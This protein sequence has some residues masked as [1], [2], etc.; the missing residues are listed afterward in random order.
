MDK[1]EKQECV[2]MATKMYELLE[3]SGKL[4]KLGKEEYSGA[5]DSGKTME[6]AY[7]ALKKTVSGVVGG[8]S[9]SSGGST[10]SNMKFGRT[11]D[12]TATK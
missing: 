8:K 11:K 12:S 5:G 4:K 6:S 3:D 9:D 1:T 7:G 2:D 10:W